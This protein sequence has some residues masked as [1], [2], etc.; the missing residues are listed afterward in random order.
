MTAVP[1]TTTSAQEARR[2]GSLKTVIDA[3]PDSC[4]NNPTWKGLAYFARDLVIYLGLL[5]ALVYVTNVFYVLLIEMV[6]ALVVSA[7]F[8]VG[9][10]AAHG[11]LFKTKRLNSWVGHLAMLPS[12]HVYEGWILGHNRIHHPY[13][14]RQGFDFVW[15]PVTPEEYTS[16]GWF[17]RGL[18]R[19]EWSWFGSGIYYIHQ[20]WGTKMIVGK[21]PARWAKTIRRDRWIVA[22]FVAAMTLL[23]TMVG[24]AQGHSVAG[25]IWLDLRTIALPFFFFS[26]VIGAA[27]HVHHVA[28]DIRWWK[29]AEWSKFKAQ[30]EGTTVLRLPK[31]M[32][33]FFHWIMIHVPHHVDMR[34]PMYHLEEAADSIEEAF[35]GTVIDRP[36]KFR[37]YVSNAQRCKLYDF[38][39]GRW[40]SYREAR[41]QQLALASP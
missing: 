30:M 15:H 28:P 40:M 41:H 24:I 7:L 35:P 26:F 36:F 5:V 25:I 29:K 31:G 38:E 37:D 16:M 34:I 3:I 2:T 39:E 9:H 22:A 17:R 12:F 27:V 14:V 1:E 6:M 19:V 32:D 23:F 18:H 8:I 33:F 11:A 20:V 4:Y 13:T 21:P 10:D